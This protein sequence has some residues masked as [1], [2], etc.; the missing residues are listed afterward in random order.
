MARGVTKVPKVHCCVCWGV[1]EI[2]CGL[3]VCW[4]RVEGAEMSKWAQR[5]VRS[6]EGVQ[7]RT[8]KR[9][10]MPGGRGGGGDFSHVTAVNVF[11]SGHMIKLN[12][13]CCTYSVKNTDT[14]SSKCAIIYFLCT[15]INVFVC[16]SID[17]KQKMIKCGQKIYL[18]ISQ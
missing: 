2:C 10:H 13:C 5:L 8:F 9:F 18:E 1:K 6:V 15:Q 4:G 11:Y 16:S 7:R 12:K 17:N 3:E 14:S